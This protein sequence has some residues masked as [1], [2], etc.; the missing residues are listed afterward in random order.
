MS[1]SQYTAL[2]FSCRRIARARKVTAMQLSKMDSAFVSS[3]SL[4]ADERTPEQHFT[5][6][7]LSPKPSGKSVL[8]ELIGVKLANEICYKVLTPVLRRGKAA[9]PPPLSGQV[10]VMDTAS[11]TT[12]SET[13][14]SRRQKAKMMGKNKTVGSNST[15]KSMSDGVSERS[16]CS[17]PGKQSPARLGNEVSLPPEPSQATKKVD[18][19]AV[20]PAPGCVRKYNYAKSCDVSSNASS[21]APPPRKVRTYEIDEAGA[22]TSSSTQDAYVTDEDLRDI[23]VAVRRIQD[24]VRRG[25][26]I[27]DVLSQCTKSSAA[28]KAGAPQEVIYALNIQKNA[29]PTHMMQDVE[30]QPKGRKGHAEKGLPPGRPA[31]MSS[32][33]LSRHPMY[34][35]LEHGPPLGHQ[36]QASFGYGY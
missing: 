29:E 34:R 15:T 2:F 11:N 4:P 13:K 22:T 1:V 18:E 25:R 20:D 3:L 36:D 28:A 24:P 7:C 17:D 8:A 10:V 26:F 16:R 6:F 14:L 9:K 31:P 5:W 35:H 23:I 33:R 21:T 30:R 12:P 27:S 19:K 32:Q